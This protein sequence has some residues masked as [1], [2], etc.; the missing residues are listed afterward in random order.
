MWVSEAFN[1]G[2]PDVVRMLWQSIERFYII[3]WQMAKAH[4][5][6]GSQLPRLPCAFSAVLQKRIKSCIVIPYDN[7]TAVQWMLSCIM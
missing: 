3:R 1:F 7:P 4:G 6:H 2:G 5:S